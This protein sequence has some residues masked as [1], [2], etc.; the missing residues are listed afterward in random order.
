[1]TQWPTTYLLLFNTFFFFFFCWVRGWPVSPAGDNQAA[2]HTHTH[3]KKF[4]KEKEKVP[5]QVPTLSEQRGLC[6]LFGRATTSSSTCLLNFP[7]SGNNNNN[8]PRNSIRLYSI[9]CLFGQN[10]DNTL[11]VSFP[12]SSG[13]Q[14]GRLES[15]PII[16]VLNKTKKI[17]VSS[18]ISLSVSPLKLQLLNDLK[19]ACWP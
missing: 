18:T 14:R 11:H 15:N 13:F 17:S 10:N 2:V 3:T 5:L 1:M 19:L 12:S 7:S 4:K 8:D 16:K 6:V 9:R